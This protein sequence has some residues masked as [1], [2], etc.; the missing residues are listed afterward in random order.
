[1]PHF[2]R[3]HFQGQLRFHGER[4]H[5]RSSSDNP[6]LHRGGRFSDEPFIRVTGVSA[7]AVVEMRNGNL[8][9]IPWGERMENAEQNHR[10]HAAGKGD[11]NLLPAQKQAAVLN[12]A[13]DALEEFAHAFI[14]LILG[15]AGKRMDYCESSS[16]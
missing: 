9:A 12:F 3:G 7:Q 11:K 5:V 10:I 8:P 15:A 4:L 16:R 1:V 14:L 6:Q 2:T 13:F